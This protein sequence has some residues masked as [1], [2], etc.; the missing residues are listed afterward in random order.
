MP[1]QAPPASPWA[2]NHLAGCRALLESFAAHDIVPP[3]PVRQP[4]L[5]GETLAT[6]SLSPSPLLRTEPRRLS[7]V[8]R[9]SLG[10]PFDAGNV[11]SVRVCSGSPKP[12]LFCSGF[13]SREPA[14]GRDAYRSQ[15]GGWWASRRALASCESSSHATS[16]ASSA[17]RL[18]PTVLIAAS[19]TTASGV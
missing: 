10:R 9:L 2:A 5:G 11:L 14:S 4:L 12:L 15:P 3:T 6:T 13:R 19:A 17:N 8:H 16:E 7:A 1:R 18:T